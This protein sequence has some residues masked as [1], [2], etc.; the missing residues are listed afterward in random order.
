[1]NHMPKLATNNAE[2]L[3]IH[4]Y[5]SCP[6]TF[7][8]AL[9]EWHT[10]CWLGIWTWTL[11][12]L[13][14]WNSKPLLLHNH[15]LLC[16]LP[17][18]PLHLIL[19]PSHCILCLSLLI[20]LM[21]LFHGFSSPFPCLIPL[22]L[23]SFC[24]FLLICKLHYPLIKL[25]TGEKSWQSVAN[26]LPHPFWCVFFLFIM[27]KLTPKHAAV[28]LVQNISRLEFQNSALKGFGQ[29][30]L[31]AKGVKKQILVC[32]LCNQCWEGSGKLG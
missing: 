1:M 17:C 32:S 11:P 8:L 26:Q 31:C 22:C 4:H 23:F 10:L 3:S 6:C 2:S 12:Q 13:W 29:L 18:S 20:Y 25:I 28:H 5:L 7:V 30:F 21:P 9:P 16:S 14:G 24:P 19:Q 15:H 27:C